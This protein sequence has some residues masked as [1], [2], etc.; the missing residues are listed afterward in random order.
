MHVC[1]IKQ[2]NEFASLKKIIYE[3]Y[4][5]VIIIVVVVVIIIIHLHLFI[6]LPIYLFIDIFY[7]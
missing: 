4:F 2:A 6:Y 1:K 7:I 3:T 5:N